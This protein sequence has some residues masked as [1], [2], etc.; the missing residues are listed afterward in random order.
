MYRFFT[1]LLRFIP[2]YLIV[3]GT[4]V[5]GTDTLIYLSA[6]SLLVYKNATDFCTL[7]SCNFTEFI[8]QR[9]QFFGGVF[10]AFHNTVSCHL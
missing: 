4:I 8:Y 3:F 9:W 5:N 7:I 10:W 1:S 6:A 2:R